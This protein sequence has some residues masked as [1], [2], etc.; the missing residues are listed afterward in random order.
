MLTEFKSNREKSEQ[1]QRNK[2]YAI[3]IKPA[4][5]NDSEPDITSAIKT[6][7]TIQESAQKLASKL[8]NRT[9]STTIIETVLQCSIAEQD[10]F[11]R[12]LQAENLEALNTLL[13]QHAGLLL[14]EVDGFVLIGDNAESDEKIDL[15]Q[16]KER[17]QA[18]VQTIITAYS[19]TETTLYTHH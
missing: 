8:P 14:T 13:Q 4:T 7:Q 16:A 5:T 2:A 17:L 18:F 11:I 10:A 1:T 12:L 15:E 9:D 19:K 6:V 3:L